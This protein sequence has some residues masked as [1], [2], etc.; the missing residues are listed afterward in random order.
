MIYEDVF[1]GMSMSLARQG[2]GRY[3]R[4]PM[5]DYL[6]DDVSQYMGDDP[7]SPQDMLPRFD[8]IVQRMI[9]ERFGPPRQEGPPE[10][11]PEEAEGYL[12]KMWHGTLGGLGI[13]GETLDATGRFSRSGIAELGGALGFEKANPESEFTLRH[14]AGPSHYAGFTRPE[15]ETTERQLLTQFFGAPA[16]DQAGGL[17]E[18][19]L[20]VA[21]IG[22]GIATDPLSYI[23]MPFIRPAETAAGRATRHVGLDEGLKYVASRLDMGKMGAREAA[24][25][26]TP[27][28]IVQAAEDAPKR[29]LMMRDYLEYAAKNNTSWDDFADIP[30]HG[31]WGASWNP[32]GANKWVGGFGIRP[33]IARVMDTLGEGIAK[34]PIIGPPVRMLQAAFEAAAGSQYDFEKQEVFRRIHQKLPE[35][36]VAMHGDFN[37]FAN[38]RKEA[39]GE[40]AKTFD[41]QLAL[42]GPHGIPTIAHQPGDVVNFPLQM[43][44][45]G[46][47]VTSQGLVTEVT[48]RGTKVFWFDEAT[49]SSRTIDVP[50]AAVSSAGAKE[51]LKARL[52]DTRIEK[53]FDNTYRAFLETEDLKKS[54]QRT[55]PQGLTRAGN[56]KALPGFEA[57]MQDSF[58]NIRMTLGEIQNTLAEKGVKVGRIEGNINPKTGLP[59]FFYFPRARNQ[60]L[61]ERESK[62]RSI[63]RVK[64]SNMEHRSEATAHLPTAVINEMR[65]DQDVFGKDAALHIAGKYGEYLGQGFTSD[66][67]VH[68]QQLADYFATA[69]KA[70]QKVGDDFYTHM[71]TTDMYDYLKGMTVANTSVDAAYDILIHNMEDTAAH[72]VPLTSA[73]KTVQ[74]L[75]GDRALDYLV[76][77]TGKTKQELEK[78]GVTPEIHRAMESTISLVTNP[79]WTDEYLGIVGANGSFFRDLTDWWKTSLTQPWPAHAMRNLGSGQAVNAMSGIIG[80][81]R[82]LREYRKTF[83]EAMAL[84]KNPSEAFLQELETMNVMKRDMVG[85]HDNP[86]QRAAFATGA[87]KPF[88]RPGEVLQEARENIVSEP[89]RLH[90]VA[91][92]ATTPMGQ[93]AAKYVGQPLS[94]AWDKLRVAGGVPVGMGQRLN[95]WVEWQNRVTP[96]LYLRKKGWSAQAAA[97]KVNELQ[98]DYSDLTKFEKTY[99]RGG[100]IPFYTFTRKMSGLLLDT[101]WKHPTGPQAQLIK[102]SHKA[103]NEGEPLPEYV[104]EGLAIDAPESIFGKPEPGNTQ[105]ITGFGFAHEDPLQF[106]GGS[107]RD[108]L[109]ELGSRLN[110][111]LKAPIEYATGQVLFQQGPSGGRSLEDLDPILGRIGSNIAYWT[112]HGE[113]ESQPMH[114]NPMVEH[115]VAN[116]PFSRLLSTTR[117]ITDVNKGV[118]PKLSNVLTGMRITNVTP[119]SRESVLSEQLERSAE[120]L[121]GYKKFVRG[122][123][124]KEI[125]N[126]MTVEQR[127]EA[128]RI[129]A[130]QS[131]LADTQRRRRKEQMAL[132]PL[133]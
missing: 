10:I 30:L 37:E 71:T 35:E 128:D 39:Y 96:Y 60:K 97:K 26:L 77:K 29:A 86:F 46:K 80:G 23:G 85:V 36:R 45:R 126:E 4:D 65:K 121:G 103:R 8:P 68:A 11:T 41:K 130:L 105:K 127:L 44:P 21:D 100:L 73:L 107:L 122:F 48:T 47:P 132:K 109:L 64:N 87:P 38:L 123:F 33:K 131:L 83:G 112:G 98:F 18:F 113:K 43:S 108:P 124:P 15:E 74:G 58:N 125:K 90:I 5:L 34:N 50:H 115:A 49:Q 66:K 118:L 63:W 9:D 20:D 129:Q 75:D 116:S 78:M 72:T 42:P 13:V 1:P 88:F 61:V 81:L 12:T 3:Q 119:R 53:M 16:E 114:V 99:L 110:P 106:V 19:A 120:S 27:R 91:N 51:Q 32:L 59:E 14:L 52:M 93:A 76:K 89:S 67:G 84:A 40:F 54:F 6:P 28:M 82:D 7:F 25:R 94:N 24:A 31:A 69:S 133:Q 111:L 17:G 92:T 56:V 2:R 101:L 55:F 22:V 117:Q 79:E 62:W 102:Q 104:A 95:Y 70:N 57:K